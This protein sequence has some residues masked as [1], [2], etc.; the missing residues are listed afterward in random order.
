VRRVLVLV[1]LT[2]ALAFGAA[3]AQP[4]PEPARPAPGDVE[5]R[6]IEPGHR[7]PQPQLMN[8]KPSGFRMN[9]MPAK[10]GAYRYRLMIVGGFCVMLTAALVARYL[11]KINRDRAAP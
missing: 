11:R 8:E 1:G 7:M 6:P 9:G 2:L 3:S 5:G 10:G 4:A